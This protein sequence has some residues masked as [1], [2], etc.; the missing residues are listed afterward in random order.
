MIKEKIVAILNTRSHQNYVDLTAKVSLLNANTQAAYYPLV[1]GFNSKMVDG[2]GDG[3]S[4]RSCIKI[5]RRPNSKSSIHVEL[6]STDLDNDG[7]IRA[8][9]YPLVLPRNETKSNGRNR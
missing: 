3:N 2:D 4:S 5:T 1:N 8:S 9:I 6:Q 7:N